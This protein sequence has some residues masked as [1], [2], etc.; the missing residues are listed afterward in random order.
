MVRVENSQSILP[1]KS[2]CYWAL[3]GDRDNKFA[4]LDRIFSKN[5]LQKM[6]Q[7]PSL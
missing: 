2:Y 3:F 7:K 5:R 4:A 6:L 1:A